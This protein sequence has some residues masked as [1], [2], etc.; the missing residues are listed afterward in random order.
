MS[1][2]DRSIDA[3][4]ATATFNK[5]AHLQIGNP[6]EASKDQVNP[7]NTLCVCM[8]TLVERIKCSAVVQCQGL[9]ESTRQVYTNPALTAGSLGSTWL[10][11]QTKQLPSSCPVKTPALHQPWSLA[12]GKASSPPSPVLPG[13]LQGAQPNVVSW[14]GMWCGLADGVWS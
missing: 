7:E 4:G 9:C 6:S 11:L 13:A 10:E 14:K 1:A 2:N 5:W 3:A 8:F 12:R